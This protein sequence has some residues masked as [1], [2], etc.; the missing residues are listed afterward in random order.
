MDEY[1]LIYERIK[2]I[3]DELG[4]LLILINMTIEENKFQREVKK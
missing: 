1:K 2:A 3:Q 4:W